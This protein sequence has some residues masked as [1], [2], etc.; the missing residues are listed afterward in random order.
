[1]ELAALD[2]RLG[3]VRAQN[4][5]LRQLVATQDRLGALVLHGADVAAITRML[6]DLIGRRLLLLDEL[7]QV[8]TESAPA[9]LG[10]RADAGSFSWAPREGYARAVLATL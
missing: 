5:A 4:G 6:A 9:G 1:A 3:T 8:V 10:R 2:A 7:L